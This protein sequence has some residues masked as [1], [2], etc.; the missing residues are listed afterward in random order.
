MEMCVVALNRTVVV[1]ADVQ[2]LQSVIRLKSGVSANG[3]DSR[4][5]PT[6][7]RLTRMVES[8]IL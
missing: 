5:A 2:R 1:Y 3:H 8:E 4:P 7:E 6:T